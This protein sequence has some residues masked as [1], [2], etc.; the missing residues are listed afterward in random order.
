MKLLTLILTLFLT[1]CSTIEVSHDYNQSVSFTKLKTFQWLPEKMQTKPKAANFELKNPFIAQR[2]KR[3]I[4]EQMLEK[5]LVVKDSNADAYITFQMIETKKTLKQP[6]TRIGL[7]LGSV[8]NYGF[9]SIGF[10]LSPERETFQQSLL[11]IDIQDKKKQL[12]WRGKSTSPV[13]KHPTPE[14][15]TELINEIIEKLLAQYPPK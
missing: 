6:K 9:G 1:G 11:S 3:A 7:G 12:L 15:T 8:F 5:G 10:D 14:E 4:E 13:E 2:I